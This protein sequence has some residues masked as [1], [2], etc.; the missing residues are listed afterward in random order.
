MSSKVVTLK[1]NDSDIALS[2]F[3]QSFFDKVLDGMV[4]ALDNTCPVDT[5]KLDAG[6][7]E[8]VLIVNGATINMNEFVRNIFR[9]T[10]EGMISSLRDIGKIN[11]FTI[12]ICIIK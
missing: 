4:A 9:S 8:T 10:A 6:N 11:S 1:V 7:G 12:Q 3:V 2:F 5:L